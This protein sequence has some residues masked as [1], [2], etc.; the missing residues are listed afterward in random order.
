MGLVKKIETLVIVFSAQKIQRK[1]PRE[2]NGVKVQER[3]EEYQVIIHH[4]N[5]LI[6]LYIVLMSLLLL[7]GLFSSVI[8]SQSL[9]GKNHVPLNNIL[10]TFG[11]MIGKERCRKRLKFI[12]KTNTR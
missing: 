9:L 12:R 2:S 5:L 6:L 8:V 3:Y 4:L 10:N 7:V 11:V 1:I